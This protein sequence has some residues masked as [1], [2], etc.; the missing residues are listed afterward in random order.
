[1]RCCRLLIPICCLTFF[2]ADSCVQAQPP[3]R[4]PEQGRGIGGQRGGAGGRQTQG[5]QAMGGRA[6]QQSPPWLNI[7]DTDSDGQISADEIKNASASLLKLDRNQ[8]GRLTGDELRPTGISGGQGRPGAPQGGP[9]GGQQMRGQQ[10]QRGARGLGGGRDGGGAAGSGRSRGGDSDQA[11][12][13]FADQIMSLDENKDGLISIAELPEHMHEAFEVADADKSG[14]LNGKELLLLASGFR[15]NKLNPDDGQEM[16]NAPTQDRSRPEEAGGSEGRQS[17]TRGGQTRG[18]QEIRGGGPRDRERPRDIEFKEKFP[19]GAALPEGLRVYNM[20]RKLVPV[21]SIFQ[22][23]YTVVV[24]GCLTCPA[25]RSSY[26]EI[27]AVARD[28]SGRGVDFYFLYQSLAHPEN[29]GFVQPTSIEDRF[30]QVEHAKELLET[31]IPWLT[32]PMDNPMKSH[33]AGTPNSQF[34]FDQSGKVVH[35]DSWGRGSSLRD[36][37]ESLVGKP[38]TFTTVQDLNLPRFERHLASESDM[39]V[40]RIRVEGVAVPLRVQAG[41]EVNPVLSLRSTDFNQSNR[42]VK[43]RPEADRDLLKTGTGQLYLGFRQDPVL[44]GKWN[45]LATAPAYKIT[46]KS[47]TV[48]PTTA[49]SPKLN[50]ESDDEPREFLVDVKGWQAGEPISVS[51]QYFVCNK[52]KGWC[53]SV[54][55]EFTVWLEQDGLAGM[56]NGRS[57]FPGGGGGRGAGQ[58]AKG[59]EGGRGGQRGGGQGRPG[60]GQRSAR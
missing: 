32:D 1:M 12:S 30:A 2:V 25:Y 54:Q 4:R 20:D 37:L 45:N 40:E 26:P 24:A 46:T 57:H 5:R 31:R 55:Q 60:A 27:E 53:Q 6:G 11:D 33:F 8:D 34:V 44:G 47:A 59:Q 15:R 9:E 38:E 23:K 52:E 19:E 35:R 18:A 3:G 49:Q 21:N 17:Q 48:S 56:V 29:W 28:F 41:G 58:G 16:K 10:G 36:S 22:S 50:V 51:I 43:L 42:Y 13:A 39:L 7:F 14:A